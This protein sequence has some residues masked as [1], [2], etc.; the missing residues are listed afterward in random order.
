MPVRLDFSRADFA[1]RFA[2]FLGAKREVSDDIERAARAIVDDVAAR[3]DSAL[4]EATA[5]FDR[6]DLDVGGLR[7]TAAEIDA[8]VK[9]RG[10]PPPHAPQIPPPP[11]QLFH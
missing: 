9:T 7:I 3:G 11:L 8:A 2:A 5:K 6:L 10:T 1:E 4:I